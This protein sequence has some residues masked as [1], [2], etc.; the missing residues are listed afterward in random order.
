[1]DKCPIDTFKNQLVARK[2]LSEETYHSMVKEIDS[3]LESAI[4][5]ARQS[6]FPGPDEVLQDVYYQRV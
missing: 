1:M 6:A 4:Q 3:Q 2:V 5:S